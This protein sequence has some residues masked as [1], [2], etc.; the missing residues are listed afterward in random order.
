MDIQGEALNTTAASGLPRADAGLSLGPGAL[1]SGAP[2]VLARPV[3][4]RPGARS[5]SSGSWEEVV[6][7]R[8]VRPVP[9]AVDISRHPCLPSEGQGGSS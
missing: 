8:G 6:P 1:T 2:T 3:Q 4:D 5:I 9:L 7:D